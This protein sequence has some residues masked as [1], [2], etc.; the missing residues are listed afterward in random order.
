MATPTAAVP[1]A[2]ASGDLPQVAS[3][4][5]MN[6]EREDSALD[7]AEQTQRPIDNALNQQRIDAWHPILDPVWVIVALFYLGIILIPV[8]A[9]F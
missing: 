2:R 5:G 3:S 4:H 6:P 7:L 8:G 1:A 9:F